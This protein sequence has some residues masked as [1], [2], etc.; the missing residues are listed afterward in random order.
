M[1]GSAGG[2]G[3]DAEGLEEGLELGVDAGVVGGF[4]DQGFEAVLAHFDL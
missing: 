4:G 1:I 2:L 3:S